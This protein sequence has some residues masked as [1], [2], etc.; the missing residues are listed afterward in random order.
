P[1]LIAGLRVRIGDRIVDNSLRRQLD[2]V[3]DQV[4]QDLRQQLG[5]PS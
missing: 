2:Q 1:S 5:M 3:R 4:G